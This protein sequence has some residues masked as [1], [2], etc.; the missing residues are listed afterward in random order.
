MKTHTHTHT[1]ER[2]YELRH[3]TTCYKRQTPALAGRSPSWTI[4]IVR[5]THQGIFSALR[6]LSVCKLPSNIR[7]LKLKGHVCLQGSTSQRGGWVVGIP[8]RQLAGN[9]HRH[10]KK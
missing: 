1:K 4:L 3:T 5:E 6:V 2:H 7:V 8:K 9:R 10:S